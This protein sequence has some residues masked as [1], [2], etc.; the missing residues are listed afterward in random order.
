MADTT[1]REQPLIFHPPFLCSPQL[2]IT[3][4][5]R[6]AQRS[7]RVA[8]RHEFVRDVTLKIQICDR[9]R[10]RPPVQFLRVVNL[11]ASGV[12]AGVEVRA[13]LTVLADGSAEVAFRDL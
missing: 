7:Q 10:D 13:V 6:L 1:E 4:Q 9:L 8:L 2:N 5:Y 11:V 3:Q 12:A